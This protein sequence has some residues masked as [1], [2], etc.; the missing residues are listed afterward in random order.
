MNTAQDGGTAR[1]ARVA[2]T[3]HCGEFAIAA[4][5]SAIG[6]AMAIGATA[7]P[8]GTLDQ[9]GPAFLPSA[10]GVLLIVLGLA[11]ALS[12]V[13]SRTAPAAAERIAL[14]HPRAVIA[15]AS[16]VWLGL[17]FE[18]FGAEITLF[19]FAL[20]SM[21]WL[22]GRSW[23]A[24]VVVAAAVALTTVFLFANLLGVTLP[25]SWPLLRS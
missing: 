8:Y 22:A 15:L 16:I 3:R 14:V 25:S 9:P 12:C 2:V 1:T 4:L 23:F 20:I 13:R 5:T 19:V 24:S 18:R 10:L 17:A 11:R 6:L 21:R 7:L